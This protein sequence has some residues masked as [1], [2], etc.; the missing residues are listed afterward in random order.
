[1]SESAVATKS[2]RRHFLALGASALAVSATVAVPAPPASE[3]SFTAQAS[4]D[5]MVALDFVV[6]S[7]F[8]RRS[9]FFIPRLTKSGMTIQRRT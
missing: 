4:I 2:N 9:F 6:M 8:C 3:A 5:G 1:M 7:D